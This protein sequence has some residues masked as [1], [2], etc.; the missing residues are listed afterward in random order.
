MSRVVDYAGLFPPAALPLEEAIRTYVRH[1]SGPHAWMLGPFVCPVGRLEDALAILGKLQDDHPISVSLLG[2]ATGK[3][4]AADFAEGLRLDLKLAE[5][6]RKTGGQPV[7]FHSFEVKAP[8]GAAPAFAD[9]L[10][11]AAAL[12]R[13]HAVQL[14]V[15]LALD[16]EL[17]RRLAAAA[18][19]GLAAKFRTGGTSPQAFPSPQALAR[20]LG[21]ALRTPIAFKCTA[22]LHHPIRRHDH[23]L[24]T[25]MHGFVN[26]FLA[27]VL[28]YRFRWA[29]A[30]IQACLEET[31]PQAFR[32]EPDGIAWREWRVSSREIEAGRAST[33]LSFGSCSFD[34]PLSDL[35]ALGWL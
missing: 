17:P 34:E 14:F 1:R 22:G 11:K 7:A 13:R 25:P 4:N 12:S 3:E 31:D 10:A 23:E 9:A 26:V 32:I 5:A 15:E 28:G 6:A 20:G 8:A 19:A 24:G 30:P 18:A 35:R 33:A 27:G 21:A 2:R 29:D 16:A